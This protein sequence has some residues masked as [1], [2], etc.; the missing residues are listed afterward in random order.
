MNTSAATPNDKDN[1]IKSDVNQ[2]FSDLLNNVDENHIPSGFNSPS[3]ISSTT[4]ANNS[5]GNGSKS[6]FDYEVHPEPS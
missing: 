3:L 5:S 6:V 2:F 1:K 4:A